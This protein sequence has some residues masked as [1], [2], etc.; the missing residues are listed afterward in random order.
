MHAMDKTTEK[1]TIQK[2]K[3]III[4]LTFCIKCRR[5]SDIYFIF[6]KLA[7]HHTNTYMMN[8]KLI[9]YGNTSFQ[10]NMIDI[11]TNSY[12]PQRCH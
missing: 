12:F 11:L 1:R 5:C 6:K 2:K 4:I 10:T 3:G 9:R 7:V 8:M